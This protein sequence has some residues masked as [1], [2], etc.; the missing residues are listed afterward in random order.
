[1]IE[2]PAWAPA[3]NRE[4]PEAREEGDRFFAQRDW[5]LIRVPTDMTVGEFVRLYH[6]RNTRGVREALQAQL[7]AF[8]DS[9]PIRKGAEV[10]LHLTVP[11]Q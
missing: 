1:M 3:A 10:R 11:S 8:N 5:V 7:G 4:A 2:E 6:L 9:D